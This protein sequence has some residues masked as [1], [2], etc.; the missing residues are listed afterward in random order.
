LASGACSKDFWINALSIIP[1]ANVELLLLI[2]NFQFDVPRLRVPEGV[3]QGHSGNA[4]NFVSA[5]RVQIPRLAERARRRRW[6][7]E[8]C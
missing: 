6:S 5:D 4:V 3:S 8:S 7:D 2:W 1:N